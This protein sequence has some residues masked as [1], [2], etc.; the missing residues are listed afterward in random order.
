MPGELCNFDL[1]HDLHI[2]FFQT[3]ISNSFILWIVGQIDAK[4]KRR[5]SVRHWAHCITLTYHHTHELDL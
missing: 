4:Q 5:E 3:Q 2:D 1:A